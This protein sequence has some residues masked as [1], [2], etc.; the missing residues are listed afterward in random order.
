MSSNV[1]ESFTGGQ[2]SLPMFSPMDFFING[3]GGLTTDDINTHTAIIGKTGEGKTHLVWYHI[4]QWSMIRGWSQGW[5]GV[6]MPR[7]VRVR[8]L[9][10]ALITD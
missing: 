10:T 9:T 6:I 3:D 4:M 8:C 2:Q 7:T 5:V 1:R